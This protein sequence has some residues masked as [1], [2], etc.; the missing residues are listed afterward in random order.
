MKKSILKKALAATLGASMAL[1]M[2]SLPVF[3]DSQNYH[4]YEVHPWL[5]GHTVGGT[6]L[7]AL[8]DYDMKRIEF[9]KSLPEG[10]QTEG[11]WRWADLKDR[12]KKNDIQTIVWPDTDTIVCS[13]SANGKPGFQNMFSGMWTLKA[14]RNLDK[15]KMK[16]EGPSVNWNGSDHRN[17]G[18]QFD[19]CSNLET[20]D[21]RHIDFT[22]LDQTYTSIW[23]NTP[24]AKT[25]ILPN[26]AP[27]IEGTQEKPLNFYA[28]FC[29]TGLPTGEIQ[30]FLNMFSGYVNTADGAFSL[31][32][33][34]KSVDLSKLSMTTK[35]FANAFNGGSRAADDGDNKT[36]LSIV[37]PTLI[38]ADTAEE[39]TLP[40][41][42]KSVAGS[43]EQLKKINAANGDGLD[44]VELSGDQEVKIDDDGVMI[45]PA[46]S[47]V[48]KPD[49]TEIEIPETVGDEGVKIYDAAG[50]TVLPD[51]AKVTKPNEDGTKTVI[52]AKEGSKITVNGDVKLTEG[53][54]VQQTDAEGEPV[55]EPQTAG[56]DGIRLIN[57]NIDPSDRTWTVG[58]DAAADP[59]YEWANGATGLAPA[60]DST[61]IVSKNVNVGTNET[62][63]SAGTAAAAKAAGMNVYAV[64]PL[65]IENT[66][67]DEGGTVNVE[68]NVDPDKLVDDKGNTVRPTSVSLFHV[69]KN[70]EGANA[71]YELENLPYTYATG[72][73]K[74]KTTGFSDFLLGAPNF[75]D[76]V[77]VNFKDETPTDSGSK[78][79]GIYV[80][81]QAGKSIN[82][83]NNVDLTFDTKFDENGDGDFSDNVTIG[84]GDDAKVSPE[85]SSDSISYYVEANAA[86]GVTLTT[87]VEKNEGRYDFKFEK[88][89]DAKKQG[90][91]GNEPIK[92]GTV[93]FQGL[94]KIVFTVKGD[95]TYTKTNGGSNVAHVATY[96]NNI[97]EYY[98]II[99]TITNGYTAVSAATADVDYTK[100]PVGDLTSDSDV[101]SF[102]VKVP[103]T[104]KYERAAGKWN[105]EVENL[106]NGYY[107]ALG[108][109]AKDGVDYYERKDHYEEAVPFTE[110]A[111]TANVTNVAGK[112]TSDDG[113]NFTLVEA[114][115]TPEAGAEYFEDENGATPVAAGTTN[116][117]GKYKKVTTYELIPSGTVFTEAD[118]SLTDTYYQD[119]N[120]TEPATVTPGVHD[121]TLYKKVIKY[122]QV[123]ATVLAEDG[124]TYYQAEDITKYFTKDETDPENI[125]YTAVTAGTEYDSTKTYYTK[126]GYDYVK[127]ENVS[128]GENVTGLY[129]VNDAAVDS[130]DYP[131]P[132]KKLHVAAEAG[133][134]YDVNKDEDRVNDHTGDYVGV[135]SDEIKEATTNVSI[136][137]LFRNKITKH[138]AGTATATEEEKTSLKD[139]MNSVAYNNMPVEL[140]SLGFGSNES[141]ALGYK[142]ELGEDAKVGYV[143]D[144]TK[145]TDGLTT[146]D[147]T[148]ALNYVAE[149]TANNT[150]E[151]TSK[152]I[153]AYE[154]TYYGED[155]ITVVFYNVPSYYT[156]N[157][158]V[159]GE[160]DGYRTA[161]YSAP[162]NKGNH[163]FQFWNNAQDKADMNVNVTMGT[164][165]QD[166][167]FLAG[168]IREDN[169]IDIYDLSAAVSYFGKG[170][171]GNTL[172]ET[173]P[174]GDVYAQYDLNRDGRIDSRDVAYVLVSWG[175]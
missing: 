22:K 26:P 47:K 36:A 120:G 118:A 85:K 94:G 160:K 173:D 158:T 100:I 171:K 82:R 61:V 112:Y 3:A 117:A 64:Y 4:Y 33:N 31:N 110:I 122:E 119:S 121:G 170:E 142:A 15:L 114:N 144:P 159:G 153:K 73:Y 63:W 19:G 113:K 71:T 24:N 88:N 161:R 154:Q 76:D 29:D 7:Y 27:H 52:T 62:A 44:T 148:K 101:S 149:D 49:G 165:A 25:V 105:P 70:G 92:I 116:V 151:D 166:L 79:Y 175:K 125:V 164:G 72:V 157:I 130:A 75:A 172:Y 77:Y 60:T 129:V 55:G 169:V 98:T 83:L 137:I 18:W 152:V 40:D 68:L 143:A 136:D 107:R 131:Y 54:T 145:V 126:D 5:W 13:Y 128:A 124:K 23:R 167:N 42:V 34:M 6:K 38:D 8:L 115:V 109:K 138:I 50:N 16:Y 134:F 39:I 97:T 162:I 35:T 43:A 66:N 57:E 95:V 56:S 99:N 21:F 139:K 87:T 133:G 127:K 78:V 150:P 163:K 81:P 65:N 59:D 30:K 41:A 90:V 28:A 69:K 123:S 37:M 67:I 89:G 2:V 146:T 12:A 1:S 51:G 17:A 58:K 106:G 108:F 147:I 48:T 135:I 96:N 14:I 140:T 9:I 80:V 84:E 20:L 46:G 156:A 168:D 141:G 132:N 86:N 93:T 11:T 74:F 111:A 103:G 45:A 155:K 53:T 102:Y 174:N 91:A 10:V 104:E 32:P